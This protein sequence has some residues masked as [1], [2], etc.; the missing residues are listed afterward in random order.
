MKSFFMTYIRLIIP[1]NINVEVSS[2]KE[3]QKVWHKKYGTCPGYRVSFNNV[4]KHQN[5]QD[6]NID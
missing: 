1:K 2:E 3:P 5:I 6:H 4:I